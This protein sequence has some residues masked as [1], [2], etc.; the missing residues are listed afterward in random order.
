MNTSIILPRATVLSLIG[1]TLPI[2]LEDYK[3]DVL[4]EPIGNILRGDDVEN[5]LVKGHESL[6]L[7]D[8]LTKLPKTDSSILQDPAL[9][10]ALFKRGNLALYYVN[11][12]LGPGLREA[13]VDATF[14]VGMEMTRLNKAATTLTGSFEELQQY[15]LMLDHE[16]SVVDEVSK[17]KLYPLDGKRFLFHWWLNLSKGL[18]MSVS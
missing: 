4:T 17:S 16:L 3:K 1:I 5:S 15:L 8:L 18:Y 10:R 2:L 9:F 6:S 13:W 12:V 11:A 7:F 14:S